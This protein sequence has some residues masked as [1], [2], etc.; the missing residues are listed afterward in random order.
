MLRALFILL[1][2]GETHFHCKALGTVSTLLFHVH[3]ARPHWEA[4][5]YHRGTSGE[6][7]DAV[8]CCVSTRSQSM[9]EKGISRSSLKTQRGLFN[10]TAWGDLPQTPSLPDKTV[11]PAMANAYIQHSDLSRQVK[12]SRQAQPMS[13]LLQSRE[14][15]EMLARPG[16]LIHGEVYGHNWS[17]PSDLLG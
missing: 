4:L 16:F 14:S 2:P 13:A 5:R 6:W 12:A 10:D 15:H 7:G 3:V 9:Q 8:L 17:S 11:T 1:L